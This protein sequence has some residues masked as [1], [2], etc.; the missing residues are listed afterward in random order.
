M[1]GYLIISVSPYLSTKSKYGG[2]CA[3]EEMYAWT[4]GWADGV[5]KA[6]ITRTYPHMYCKLRYP[7]MRKMRV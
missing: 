1:A 7:E 4:D 5:K 2:V 6:T 3:G